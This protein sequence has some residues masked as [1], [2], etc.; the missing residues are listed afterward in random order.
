MIHPIVDR[1]YNPSP[2]Y[3][4][5]MAF[6]VSKGL[7]SNAPGVAQTLTPTTLTPRLPSGTDTSRE[8]EE[9]VDVVKR[10]LEELNIRDGERA[11]RKG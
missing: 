4:R 10:K 8:T 11:V 2:S 6:A 9:V 5:K 3:E 1:F 7:V